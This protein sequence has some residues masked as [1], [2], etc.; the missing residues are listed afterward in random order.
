MRGESY[1]FVTG[2]S[3]VIRNEIQDSSNNF[4]MAGNDPD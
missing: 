1:D 3:R 4:Q 2:S